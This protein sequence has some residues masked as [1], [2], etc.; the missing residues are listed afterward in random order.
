MNSHKDQK[1]WL[2]TIL[3]IILLFI[4]GDL[5]AHV[6]F[7]SP[8]DDYSFISHGYARTIS[9]ILDGIMPTIILSGAIIA[10]IVFVWRKDTA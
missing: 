5:I 8:A 3:A 2:L 10:G 4:L 1:A 6:S 9:M 7:A